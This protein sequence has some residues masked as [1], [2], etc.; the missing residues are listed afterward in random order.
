[1]PKGGR[2]SIEIRRER[3][4]PPPDA[5]GAEGEYARV[6]VRDTGEGIAE[7]NL[8]RLFEPFFTTKAVGE[9]SGLGLAVSYGLVR[10]HGGW[11]AVESAPGKG[12]TF[13]TFLPLG[14]PKCPAS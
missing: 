11:I 9:G 6:S 8:A 4:T 1:M 12:S 14:A 3:A 7:E 5:G 10:E 13:S 2:L